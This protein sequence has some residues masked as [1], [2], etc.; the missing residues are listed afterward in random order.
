M[1]DIN[2]L[3]RLSDVKSNVGVK[4]LTPAAFPGSHCPLH[5]ALALA[6]NIKGL[7]SLVV[8]TPECATYSR[9]VLTNT[10]VRQGELH[11]TYVLDASEV[12]FG[13]RQGVMG[14]LQ[15][16]DQAGA[17]AILLLATCVPELIGEDIENIVREV[18]PK[19]SARL[20]C[21]MLGHF[22]CN[23]F[24][25]G[26]WK[27]LQAIGSL[28]E[29]R[30]V[31]PQVVNVI[32]RSPD[33]KHIPMPPVLSALQ[34]Q[35]FSLRCLSPGSSLEDFLAAPDAALNVVLSPFT[36]PLAAAMD[37]SFGTPAFRLHNVYD[38]A[39]ID[40]LY[41]SIARKLKFQWRNEFYHERMEALALQEQAKKRLHGCRYI[42]AHIGPV[43]TI[44][45]A[46]Y[47][48]ALGMEPLLLHLE[49]FWPD[50][51]HWSETLNALGYD[52]LVCHMVNSGS[53]APLLESLSPDLCLGDL[54][55]TKF[56]VPCVPYLS[57]L[58]GMSGYERTNSLLKRILRTLDHLFMPKAGGGRRGIA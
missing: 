51:K 16:M 22:K 53:D 11:W 6:G 56:R 55:G 50:D 31:Q 38:V 23:S 25:S 26:S 57:D 10:Q 33:E 19:L 13:C 58:Y 39:E 27:T 8:G 30:R 54:S 49:E 36:D 52:P 4:F 43:R 42:C 47:L 21:V 46:A 15:K 24:P 2:H 34:Q 41:S 9:V 45:L 35:G 40:A 5:P 14:A 1:P 12:V 32:G 18:Q 3:K 44:P 20:I 48:A 7:S 37:Q 29:P 28:M 17:K